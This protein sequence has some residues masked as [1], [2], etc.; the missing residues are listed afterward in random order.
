L[1]ILGLVI[2]I[3]FYVVKLEIWKYKVCLL[4]LPLYLQNV[5]VS[6][7]IT[8]IYMNVGDPWNDEFKLMNSLALLSYTVHVHSH[9]RSLMA[10][11]GACGQDNLGGLSQSGIGAIPH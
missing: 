7:V 5:C 6:N 3:F 9:L 10:R 4:S 1:S 8:V 11:I 2:F